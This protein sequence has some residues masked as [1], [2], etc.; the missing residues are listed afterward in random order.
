MKA[1]TVATEVAAVGALLSSYPL[2]WLVGR[3]EPY[4]CVPASEPV[5]LLHGF[6]GSRS[7]L[8]ALAGY[9][10][11]A[12]FDN[13]SYFE[14]PRWQSIAD[15]AAQLGHV[16]EEKIAEKGGAAGVHLIGHSLG[17]TVARR[18]T[19]SARQGAVRTLISLGSPY[20]YGQS[21][22]REV[23]IFGDDD[24]IVPAPLEPLVTRSAFSRIVTLHDVGHLA[25]IFHPEVLRIVG[26]ELRANREQQPAPAPSVS[27]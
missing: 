4:L 14:Y 24:P 7:N 17:G 27:F 22:P 19:A 9:L 23:A 15:S 8:L 1:R 13:V 26:T 2:D 20:S 16:V 6:G 5:I 18:Y 12:G 11:L 21:S 3:V 25:L 10:R